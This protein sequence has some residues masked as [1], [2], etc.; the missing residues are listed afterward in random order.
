LR[1]AV[2]ASLV[3]G[4]LEQLPGLLGQRRPVRPS[5]V[6]RA[7]DR[8]QPAAHRPRAV[9][10]ARLRFGDSPGELAALP[11]ERRD[12]VRRQARVGRVLDVGLDHRR[13][14]PHRAC[15]KRFSRTADVISS[16]ITSLTVSGPI[17]RV[18][19]RDRRPVGHP[20][21]HRDP[22]EAPQMNRV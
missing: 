11:G 9:A 5:G 22:A 14:D 10:H 4:L 1:L 21:A 8:A 2:A 16:L 13:V 17:R 7:A 3:D 15:S 19:L 20:L 18:S 6:G 12:A